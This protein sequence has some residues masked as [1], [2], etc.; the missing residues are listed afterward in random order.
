VEGGATED[1]LNGIWRKATK[2]HINPPARHPRNP[3][4]LMNWREEPGVS[5]GVRCEGGERQV[6][7]GERGCFTFP[8]AKKKQR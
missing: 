3:R 4:N 7:S 5:G 2:K 6:K 1:S 8:I